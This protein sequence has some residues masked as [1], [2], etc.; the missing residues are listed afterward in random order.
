[1]VFGA[2]N[3]YAV[4]TS[5]LELMRTKRHRVIKRAAIDNF[6][7]TLDR[8]L[9]G[10]LPLI[11]RLRETRPRVEEVLTALLDER[12]EVPPPLEPMLTA[13]VD[14]T[15]LWSAGGRTVDIVHDEQSALTVHRINRIREVIGGGLLRD[16]EQV[17][18]RVDP[19]VQV[20]DLL[21]GVG[22]HLATQEL[23]MEIGR[24]SC[25]ERV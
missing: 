12:A 10:E 24:A 18:S 14:T 21:A 25:R 8:P 5:F 7:A 17:D 11:N 4:L 22:R 3:W 15:L 9:Y 1:M 20:A 16:F 23:Y 6:F 13:L 2:A 19:R